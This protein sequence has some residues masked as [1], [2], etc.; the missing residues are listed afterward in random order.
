MRI[1]LLQCLIFYGTIIFSNFNL[2]LGMSV[3]LFFSFFF[4]LFFFFFF[5]LS[6]TLSYSRLENDNHWVWYWIVVAG[7]C[8]V[9]YVLLREYSSFS[10]LASTLISFRI[11]AINWL[12][13]CSACPSFSPCSWRYVPVLRYVSIFKT[14]FFLSFSVFLSCF[15]LTFSSLCLLLRSTLWN[16][17]CF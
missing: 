12:I 14:S 3:W 15:L 17:F 7:A 6:L 9:T 4:S 1:T 10:W 8:A 16:V 2:F 11:V 13:L 5:F